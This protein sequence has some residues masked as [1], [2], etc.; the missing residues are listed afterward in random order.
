MV[1]RNTSYLFINEIRLCKISHRT[2]MYI[3]GEKENY[4]KRKKE[5]K[6]IGNNGVTIGVITQSQM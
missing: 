4:R 2:Q 3:Q 6:V 5:K 1:Y